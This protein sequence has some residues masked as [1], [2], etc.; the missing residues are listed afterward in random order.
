[1]EHKVIFNKKILNNKLNNLK[2][3]DIPN[4]VDRIKKINGWKKS[5]ENSNINKTK[6]KHLQGL[7]FQNF[8]CEVLGYTNSI[9]NDNWTFFQEHKTKADS[10][11]PDGILGFFNNKKKDIRV[12]IELKD[13]LTNLDEK[14]RGRD[15][16]LSP[17]EQ[18][19][20]Y[21]PKCGGKCKWVII[22]NFKEIR[23]YNASNAL[24]YEKFE[25]T[26]LTN[27]KE[28]IKFFYLLNLENLINLN[29]KSIIDNLYES[30]MEQSKNISNSFYQEY[31]QTRLNLFKDMRK[32]NPLVQELIVFEKAQKLMDRFIFICFCEDT[33]LLPENTFKNVLVNARNS[34]DPTNT[35]I[36]TQLKGLFIAIDKGNPPMNINRFNGGLFAN[37]NILDNLYIPDDLFDN[38]E[39]ISEY[40]FDTDLNV[41]ILGHIFEHSIGDIEDIKSEI[42]GDK[43]EKKEG[44]RK[45][46]GIFYTPEYVTNYIVEKCIGNWLNRK[47]KELGEDSLPVIPEGEEG[48]MP[49]LKGIR[50]KFTP[51]QLA[52]EKH[53]QFWIK[54]GEFLSNVKILDPACG[55]GAFLNAAFDYLLSE[56]KK[57]NEAHCEITGTNSLLD[58]TS[59]I[60]KNNLYGVD[61]NQESV[62]IT[63]LSLWLKTANKH[64]PLT[65]LDENILCGNSLID[66]ISIAGDRAFNWNEKFKDV[67]DNGGFDIIVGNPPYGA[68]LND[69]DK[70]YLTK[71]YSTTQYNFDT[72][73]FFFE[74]S[75]KLCKDKGYI[76]FITPNTYFV[77]EKSNLLREFLFDNYKLEELVELYDVFPDAVVEPIISIYLKEKAFLQEKF[78]VICVPRNIKLTSNFIYQG[79]K[80]KFSYADLKSKE[81]YIF[82]YHETN[83]EKRICEKIDKI[84]KPLSDY[85]NVSAGVKPYETNKG[86]PKQTKEIVKSKPYN[87]YEKKDD[88]WIPY[89][90]GENIDK[91]IDK[92]NGEYIKYGECLAAPRNPKM[93]FDK[94]IFIRQ[95]SDTL[96]ATY[97]DTGKI[98]KNTLHCIYPK[99]TIPNINLKFIL[100]L[101]NSKLLNWKFQHDNFHIV[102]KPLAETKV[103]Y[104]NRL[105]III[106]DDTS[107]YVK[108][109]DLLLDKNQEKYYKIKF[110]MTFIYDNYSPKKLSNR[111]WEFYSLEYKEFICELEKQKVKLTETQKFEL[112]S[113]FNNQKKSIQELESEINRIDN[114]LN[115]L[116]YKLY[117]LTDDEIEI[118]K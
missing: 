82:N 102:G 105:P 52:L 112:M 5:I 45:K 21:A 58:L 95:T 55:S 41:N 100:G 89:M 24:E 10:T 14:Q 68:K 50:Q 39:K 49:K 108:N 93:F 66:D 16:K 30:N 48:Y 17:V 11:V 32:Y 22:S 86:Y 92:W 37:D 38:L 59:S 6:E 33:Q 109:V 60:L 31:K 15:N 71:H 83:I 67:M 98:G 7:F 96:I 101:I 65:S 27:T 103:I 18:A 20:S 81:G 104:V 28:F 107:K 91:Y 44:K 111:L 8:F 84:S 85:L 87:G 26:Q 70:K 57:V 117:E 46:D 19:F 9:G 110:F 62:E 43:I 80:T 74:L 13:A 54:Y 90:K 79:I 2:I 42:R 47:K 4:W 53:R 40:D 106:P 97:D 73:K 115:E 94:K 3:E 36:W 34:F 25:I 61:L 116:I 118:I 99:D 1:M 35:K 88:T 23:L 64:D 78:D 76:G 113:L 114:N 51:R 56:G 63:K 77:L 72:Y 29:G 69:L 12:V 75:G